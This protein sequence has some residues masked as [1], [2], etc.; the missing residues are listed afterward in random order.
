MA[1]ELATPVARY[2]DRFH[3]LVGTGHHVASPLGAW[4]LLALA[5]PA[6]TGRAR[7]R[8]AEVLD[9][10]IDASAARAAALLADPHPA[11]ACA[12]AAWRRELASEPM[13]RWLD[14]L[15]A[16][17]EVGDIPSQDQADAWAREHSAGLIEKF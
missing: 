6:A 14:G 10:D 17:T 8:L 3:R 12:V 7:D 13:Q 11:V 9:A 1:V 15:P 5:A 2:A 4:L 16:Q